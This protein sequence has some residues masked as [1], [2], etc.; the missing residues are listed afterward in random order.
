ML[1]CTFNK[2]QSIMSLKMQTKTSHYVRDSDLERFLTEKLGKDVELVGSSN[3]T[4]HTLSVKKSD[5]SNPMYKWDQD[6]VASFLADGV[7]DF[8]SYGAKPAMQYAVDQGWIE[9]GEYVIRVSW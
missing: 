5:P 1:D 4:L 9:E 3:D 2:V 7:I 6:A 8:Q